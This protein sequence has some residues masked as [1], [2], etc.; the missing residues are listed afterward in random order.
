[1]EN[2]KTDPHEESNDLSIGDGIRAAL[3]LLKRALDCAS[4]AHAPSWDFALEIGQLYAAGLTITD[5]R[6]M[7][8]K[9]FV[10]HAEETSAPGDEHRSFTPSR[11]LNFLPTT[12]V[13]L[14]REGARFAQCENVAT[15]QEILGANGKSHPQA[16][17]KPHWDAARRELFLGD[18]LIKQFHGPAKNQEL[19]LSA[20]QKE[21]WPSSI[22]D[23]LADE[24]DVDPK[25]RLNDVVYRLNRKQIV[26]LLRFHVN[27]RGRNVRW[28]LWAPAARDQDPRAAAEPPPCRPEPA[29]G[30]RRE[31]LRLQ[32]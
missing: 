5:L 28:S 14:T 23:P 31:G 18:R 2:N 21:D 10:E 11:G 4:D 3:A 13:L 15:S 30:D 25:I 26:S 1:M 19:I 22:R 9:K 12:C 29:T 24:L 8:V 27:G 7:V 32:A 17:A 6:W 16:S 20:F